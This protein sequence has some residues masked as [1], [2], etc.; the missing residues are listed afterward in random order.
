[1]ANEEQITTKNF[2][3]L[4]CKNVTLTSVLHVIS[5]F[6]IEPRR[7]QQRKMEEGSS[8]EKNR[9]RGIHGLCLLLLCVREPSLPPPSHRVLLPLPTAMVIKPG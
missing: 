4:T 7:T 3:A 1:M 2:L 6:T 8:K 5:G 9:D